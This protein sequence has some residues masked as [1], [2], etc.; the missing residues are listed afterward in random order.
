MR[1]LAALTLVVALAGGV[2]SLAARA[3]PGPAA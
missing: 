1:R 2:L 3:A